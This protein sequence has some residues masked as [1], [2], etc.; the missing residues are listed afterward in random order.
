M[1]ERIRCILTYDIMPGHT[2]E[3]VYYAKTKLLRF[4]RRSF[5][6]GEEKRVMNMNGGVE[7][8]EDAINFY[9]SVIILS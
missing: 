4:Q 3:R 9:N 6:L 8:I 7:K 1:W 5:L 2:S